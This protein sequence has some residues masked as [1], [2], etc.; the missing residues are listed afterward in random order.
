M[1][2][3]SSIR[4]ETRA[5]QELAEWK[6]LFAEQVAAKAREL[7]ELSDSAECITIGHYREAALFAVQVL[8]NAIQNTGQSD[9]RKE[10]A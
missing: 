6:A 3:A 2:Q 9:G 8:A 7:F 10:A 5:V 4:I 1:G